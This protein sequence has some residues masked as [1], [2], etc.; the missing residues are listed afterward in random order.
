[1]RF[2]DLVL[3]GIARRR[4]QDDDAEEIAVIGKGKERECSES[5]QVV[6]QLGVE[7]TAEP[8]R[9]VFK[10]KELGR[11]P[12]RYTADDAFPDVAAVMAQYREKRALLV[13]IA[14]RQPLVLV[15]G[16]DYDLFEP[17]LLRNNIQDCVDARSQ[18]KV[19]V[20]DLYDLADQFSLI[21]VLQLLS[22]KVRGI[23][24]PTFPR[25][26]LPSCTG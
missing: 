4:A 25:R 1:M 16:I 21:H 7:Q 10:S 19:R 2:F 26:N 3:H 12:L 6:V 5:F 23:P 17:E 15:E 20:R 14:A 18:L 11:S 22:C 13:G 9:Y 24:V 8:R